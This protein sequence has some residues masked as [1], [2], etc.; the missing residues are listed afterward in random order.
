[1]LAQVKVSLRQRSSDENSRTIDRRRRAMEVY[2]M[3]AATLGSEFED[4]TTFSADQV[5]RV[6]LRKEKDTRPL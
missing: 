6:L 5:K 3:I 1:M 4:P 2:N